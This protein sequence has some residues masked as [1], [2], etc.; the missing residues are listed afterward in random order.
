[1]KS[2]ASRIVDGPEVAA[3][4]YRNRLLRPEGDEA[5]TNP[6]PLLVMSPNRFWF[7]RNKKT[8]NIK[9][10]RRNI[11]ILPQLPIEAPSSLRTSIID[12]NRDSLPE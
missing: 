9:K 4:V 1:M 10:S 8:T 5:Y 3:P 12:L 2:A 11:Y 6:R 7:L